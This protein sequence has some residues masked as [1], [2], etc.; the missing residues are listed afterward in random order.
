[1]RYEWRK[2]PNL[3]AFNAVLNRWHFHCMSN[4]RSRTTEKV[5]RKYWQLLLAIQK[6]GLA[7]ART[8]IENGTQTG[9]RTQDQL[10]KSQLLYQLSYLRLWYLDAPSVGRRGG[11]L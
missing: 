4:Y 2:Y 5:V 8:P 1:M 7:D 6:K 11:A 10:V 9:T 3:Q